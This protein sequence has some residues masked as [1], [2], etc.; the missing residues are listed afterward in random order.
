MTQFT[1]TDVEF[2]RRPHVAKLWLFEIEL[3]DSS[4]WRVHGGAGRVTLGGYEWQGVSD[5]LGRQLVQVGT[6]TDPRFGQAAKVDIVLSG[7][8][9]DFVKSV[10]ASARDMEGR[11]CNAYFTLIDQETFEMWPGGLKKLFPGYVSA[12]KI[13]R[14]G[15][16]TRTVSITVESLWHSQNFPFGGYWTY[17]SQLR[18]Y[19][20]D[21]GLQYA[22]VDIQ[23]IIKA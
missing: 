5:P 15:V 11:A 8:N 9:A 16:G 19:P 14:Q 2:L 3:T 12:P 23:E 4:I 13:Y 6:V 17:S 10:K 18:R 1:E 7:A 22:G 20:G 21:K